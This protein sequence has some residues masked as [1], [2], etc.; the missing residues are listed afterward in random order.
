MGY[1][2]ISASPVDHTFSR[3]KRPPAPRVSGKGPE[4]DSKSSANFSSDLIFP[5]E[6]EHQDEEIGGDEAEQHEG[7]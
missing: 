1:V 4:S 7:R 5:S 2:I 6:S 3:K